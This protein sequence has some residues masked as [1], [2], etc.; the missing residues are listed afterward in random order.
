MSSDID[1]RQLDSSEIDKNDTI[2]VSSSRSD[3]IG[4]HVNKKRSYA[5]YHLELG[6]SDFLLHTC[7]VC[8]LRYALGDE[9]DEKV[10]KTFHKIYYEGIQFK[11]LVFS[12]NFYVWWP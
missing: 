8:G 7:S 4:K 2:A 1:G 12:L 10:H 9:G 5:Q 11:V 6:Q 3:P